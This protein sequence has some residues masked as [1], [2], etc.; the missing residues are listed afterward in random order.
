VL[1][2]DDLDGYQ[3]LPNLECLVRRCCITF[4][5]FILVLALDDFFGP[6]VLICYC[7]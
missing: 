5:V 3:S 4:V 6:L 2:R 1:V 7:T